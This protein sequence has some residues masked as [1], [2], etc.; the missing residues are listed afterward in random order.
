MVELW[1]SGYKKT[2]KGIYKLRF[3][4]ADYFK[5]KRRIVYP[6]IEVV[7]KLKMPII[8]TFPLRFPVMDYA[9]YRGN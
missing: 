4:V 1:F 5:S 8:I 7:F 2:K 3:L 6:F 9:T